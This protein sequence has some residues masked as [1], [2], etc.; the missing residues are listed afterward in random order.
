MCIYGTE[1]CHRELHKGGLM[2]VLYDKL[3]DNS[4]TFNSNSEMNITSL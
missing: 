4:K 3:Y 2:C 1:I